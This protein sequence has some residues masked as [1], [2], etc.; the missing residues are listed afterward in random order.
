MTPIKIDLKRKTMT[1]KTGI[2]GMFSPPDFFRNVKLSLM[3]AA[4]GDHF[5]SFHSANQGVATR[6]ID[7]DLKEFTCLA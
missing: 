7:L 1:R 6:V 3:K 5:D 4:D 2:R